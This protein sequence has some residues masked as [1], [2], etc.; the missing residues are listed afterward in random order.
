CFISRWLKH[1]GI[2]AMWDIR[3]LHSVGLCYIT[4]VATHGNGQI[5]TLQDTYPTWR[6]ALF[7]YIAVNR[8]IEDPR[9]ASSMHEIGDG[10]VVKRRQPPYISQYYQHIWLELTYIIQ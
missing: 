1:F 2:N 3:W 6:E 7:A 8:I 5:N 10:W 4:T 9:N